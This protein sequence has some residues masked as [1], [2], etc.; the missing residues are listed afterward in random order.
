[1]M[2]GLAFAG[3]L[4]TTA[5][6]APEPELSSRDQDLTLPKFAAVFGLESRATLLQ[7]SDTAWT[8]DKSGVVDSAAH[9]VTW[10]ITATKGATVGGHLVVDGYLDVI[11]LGTGPATLGNIVVNLQ[12]R[13][14]SH[15]VTLSS[16]VA[17]ATQGDAATSAHVVGANTTEGT[18]VFSENTASGALSFMDRRYNTM[19]SLVPE[20]KIQPWTDLPLLFSAAYDNNVLHLAQNAKLRFE[21]VITFGNHPL[22]GPNHT[23][24]NV[25][26]NGN[27][28]VDPDEHKVR[29]IIGLFEKNVPAT[30]AANST[31]ALSDTPADISTIGTVTFTNPQ[32][33]LGATTGTVKVNY[34]AGASG[35]SITNCVHGTGTG[36]TDPVGPFTFTA[37]P[38]LS[39]T[40]CTTIPISQPV[41]TPGTMGCGWHD[42]DEQSYS[43]NTWGADPLV[44]P[45]AAIVRDRFDATHPSGIIIGGSNFIQL[46]SATPVLDYL[47]QTGPAAALNATQVDPTSSSSGIYGG[48]VAG[49]R[50]NIDFA[51][52]GDTAGTAAIKYGDITLCNLT[53]TPGL[54]GTTIRALQ[55]IVNASLG[56]DPTPYSIADLSALLMQVNGAFEGGFATTWAQDHLVNGACF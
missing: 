13:Q 48:Q 24:E 23:D 49:L 41:C 9:T 17:D 40:T 12:A 5:C 35:G 55:P 44:S 52:T 50:L 25:D 19:F 28:I 54:N 15:W 20:A 22:G 43:Q 18:N 53:A 29:S 3:V 51:D 38:A 46:T 21:V 42:G 39:L 27:G 47:P 10:T 6:V 26:I 31:L 1:M 14:G 2:R 30:Q 8:L 11:N 32:I 45:P 34:D 7:T 33:S 56:G 4:L 37:V 36:V 16:D